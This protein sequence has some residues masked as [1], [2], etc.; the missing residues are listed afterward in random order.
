MFWAERVIFYMKWSFNKFD[1]CCIIN[2]PKDVFEK[3]NI[4]R[5]K[6]LMEELTDDG[7]KTFLLNMGQI[8]KINDIG[9]GMIL[10]LYKFSF[11]HE[12]SLK[13]YNLQYYISQLIFQTRLNII[14]DICELDDEILTRSE[15]KVALVA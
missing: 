3:E 8:S 1:D 13:L 2:L 9:L 7:C 4:D 11:Y 5:L 6:K 15:S 10:G 14:F 12:V